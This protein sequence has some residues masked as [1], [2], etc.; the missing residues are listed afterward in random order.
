MI[1]FLRNTS[2]MAA[3]LTCC[4]SV[5]A[6]VTEFP[7]TRIEE[8]T[9]DDFYN[10][11]KPSKE[12]Q[13]L[14]NH[15][16]KFVEDFMKHPYDPSCGMTLN[17][18]GRQ[19]RNE[20]FMSLSGPLA[21]IRSITNCYVLNEKDGNKIPVRL[22]KDGKEPSDDLIIFVHGGG[23]TQGN[24][25]T[26]DYLCRK[27]AKILKKDVLAI[28]Y[29]L[30]PENPYPKPLEDVISVYKKFSNS[31]YD[32]L[33]LCGDSGGAHLCS[34]AC[35]KIYEE[36]LKRPHVA[37]LF[38]PAISNDFDSRSYKSFGD[39]L[40]L[41]KAATIAFTNNLVG[42]DCQSHKN[43][44]NKYI[45]PVLQKDMDAF[46]REIIV[47]SG[48]DLLYDGQLEHVKNML[49]SGRKDL[50]WLVYR[51]A[52]HGFMMYGKYYDKLI[53]RVCNKIK[54]YLDQADE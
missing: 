2:L 11:Q 37:I 38:Y 42:G 40:A 10:K 5:S 32:R 4:F 26:H 28:D 27:L 43:R 29:R 35:I 24:L 45:Y 19:K 13:K 53:T 34:A 3:L 51:G 33:L 6:A 9:S 47:S 15:F 21:K 44:S 22:Y 30:A 20:L 49:R 17:E 39:C 52:A 23:W 18:F 54:K 8:F 1:N 12:T 48:Y 14:I 7:N 25:E 41:T 16:T 50:T 36:N 46:P 31:R